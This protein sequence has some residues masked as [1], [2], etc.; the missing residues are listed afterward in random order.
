MDAG[1]ARRREGVELHIEA[2]VAGGDAGV[3][4]DGGHSVYETT[5]L[6]AGCG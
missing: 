2:L 3:A 1:A 5:P 4:D 6:A